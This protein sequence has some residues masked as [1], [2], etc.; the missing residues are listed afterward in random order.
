MSAATISR[1]DSGWRPGLGDTA[2]LVDAFSGPGAYRTSRGI[3]RASSDWR[4]GLGELSTAEIVAR[5]LGIPL[6]ASSRRTLGQT[7][8]PT[9][10][11]QQIN[12]ISA[13]ASTGASATVGI[14]VAMG[15]LTGP[16]GA[17][18]AGVIAVAQLLVSVFHGCGET[19]VEAT[20]IVNQVEP[21][22]QQNLATY[23]ASPVHT[24]SLQAAAMN[25]FQTA[26]NA[27][28]QNC[29]N[30]QLLSAGTNCVAERQQGSCAYK[31]SPGGWQQA[32]D[33]SWTYV[34]PGANG[35]GSACWNWFVGYLDPIQNDPTVVPDSV[36]TSTA[37]GTGVAQTGAGPDLTPL[38]LI[39]GL[40]LAVWMISG[41]L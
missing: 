19:C 13:I 37:A 28:V 24:T 38:L 23:L 34:Y 14:L 25:N 27:V 9:P 40:G 5:R 16:V 29:Q 20:T 8:Q 35:S 6:P 10:G 7:V 33:G 26:W 4:P 39:G 17:A 22:L 11:E 3:S 30:P 1:H 18:I 12:Q 41:D 2:S 32:S 36:A 15:T 31:T 21:I